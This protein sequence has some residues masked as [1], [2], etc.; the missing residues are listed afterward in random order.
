MVNSSVKLNERPVKVAR[1]ADLTGYSKDYIYQLVHRGKIPFHKRGDAGSKGTLRF[2]ESE[3]TEWIMKSFTPSV[4]DLYEQAN[5][6]L[7]GRM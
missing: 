5:K 4:S 6:I 3:V 2:F 7:E 1:I